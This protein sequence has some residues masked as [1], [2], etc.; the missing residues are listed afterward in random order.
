MVAYVYLDPANPPSEIMLQWCSGTIGTWEHRAYWGANSLVFGTNGTAGRYYMGALPATGQWVPLYVPASAVGLEGSSV[1]GMCFTLYDGRATWDAAGKGTILQT[2]SSTNSGSGTTLTNTA[3]STTNSSSGVVVSTITTT[4]TTNLT[5]FVDWVDDAVPAGAQTGADGGDAWNWVSSNPTPYSGTL[6]NQST[7]ASGEHQHYFDWAPSTLNVNTGDVM[8]AYVYLDPANPPSEIMLQWCSGTIGTWEHRAYWGANSLVFGTNGTAGRYYMGALPA[9]GQWVP[10]YVPASAVGLEGS[11]VRGMCFTLYDGRATWD[12]A[13]K[14]TLVQVVSTG[15][16]SGSGPITS[17]NGG[18][19]TTTNTSGSTNVTVTYTNDSPT[20]MSAVDDTT[21]R[22]PQVG[23]NGLH[24]LSP[25]MLELILINTKQPDPALPANW[26]FAD[27]SGNYTPPSVNEFSVT[28]NGQAVAVQSIGFKRRTLYQ[29]MLG[30]DL[31]IENSIYLQLAASIPSNATVVVQNPDT[32]LWSPTMQFTNT[33]N[34]LRFS[35]AIH[36]NQEGYVP[37]FPKQAMVGY[38]LGSLGEMPV[39]A[40]TSFSLVDATT[41]S[42]VYQGTLTSRP[43]TGWN[44]SPTPY[45][46]VMMADFSGFTTPGEYQLVVP[47][48]GASLPFLIN[49]GIAM[50]FARAY[51]LGLYE[52]RCGTNNVMPYTRF[53]HGPCH[54]AP[55][56]VPLPESSYQFTWS[57]IAGYSSGNTTQTAPQLINN[58]TTLYPFVNTGTVD[59]HGGHHDAGDYSKYTINVASLTHFLCFAADSLGG[60]SNLDNLGIPESGDGISDVLQECKWEADYLCRLQ[61][62]DGGFYFIVYPVNRE[63]ESNVTPDHGDPQV[64]W[65][66]NTACSAAATAA[67]AQCASSPAFKKAYPAAAALY[68]QKAK[69]GWQFLTNAVAKYGKAGAYQKITFYG[70]DFNDDD[71]MAWAACQMYLA[72]GDQTAHQDLLSW[73]NPADPATWR[74]GW[75]HMSECY[76]NAIR[77]YAFA[78]Q[79]GRV[80]STSQLDAT[81]LAKCQAEIAAAANDAVTWSQQ[82]AYGTSFPTPT[83]DVNAAGWYFGDDYAFDMA[84][85]YQLN[86]QSSYLN[87]IVANM[88]YEGGCN[89]VNVSYVTGLGW[90]RNRTIVSQMALNDGL[91]LPPSGMPVGNIQQYFPNIGYPGYNSESEELCFPTDG[92][93]TAPY[94]FYDRW[95]DTWNVTTEM[96]GLNLARGLADLS[97]LATLTSTKSQPYVATAGQIVLPA[98]ANGTITATFQ[99]PAG[100]DLTGARVTWEASYQEPAYGPSYTFTP[101]Y[102]G[103]QYIHAEAQWPDGRRSFATNSYNAN[104]PLVIWVDGSLPVGA[105]PATDGVDA[106]NWISSNP[107]PYSGT[108]AHQSLVASGEHQH[109][110]TG[111]TGTMHVNTGDTLFAYIYI[112]PSNPP[113]EVMLQWNDG[114]SWDHRAFWGADSI[115]Y[116]NDGTPSRYNAGALPA[117]GKWIQLAVPASAVGV[118]GSTLNGMSFTLYNGRAAWDHAGKAAQGVTIQ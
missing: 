2:V 77:S 5:S 105:T 38:Y 49:D 14:G 99:P 97:F 21:G 11:S 87:A 41:G 113:T 78:V 94:P 36:V 118:E 65:P 86:P 29:A 89:P 96:V 61:D 63:Y 1:R 44:Y 104:A 26:D 48:L 101:L 27:L 76:G 110:F 24:I 106:W 90:K 59:V 6:A 93:T 74:W 100:M 53:D 34:P 3:A 23:D 91:T 82:S 102:S 80:Q 16:N 4:T 7:V 22:M 112:D 17:T 45:Q 55:A 31:R 67:L 30:Y 92:A 66:K 15:T 42:A 39:P 84:V 18:P 20:V 51:A 25:N 9:T 117:A 37:A 33:A 43:D 62:A 115:S 79:S 73:F 111:A 68:L 109:Y 114:S 70:D 83:K 103:Q 19:G 75:W 64:V 69:L 52:Q 58:E 85:A 8:V 12:A 57:T 107:T 56:S 54:T 47:G 60:V 13:G 88:N 72:T 46:N 50:D 28:V 95:G 81:F 71:E 40:S 98:T 32:T 116:G 10:L 35:P 108:L